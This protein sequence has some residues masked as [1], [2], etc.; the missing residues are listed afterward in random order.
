[1]S[2]EKDKWAK[3]MTERH[4]ASPEPQQPHKDNVDRGMSGS[5]QG[6]EEWQAFYK[7]IRAHVEDMRKQ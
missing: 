3:A 7:A 2:E 5:A 6:N 1:M 4:V